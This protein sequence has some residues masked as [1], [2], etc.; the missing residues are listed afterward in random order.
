MATLSLE[1][2]RSLPSPTARY[3][4]FRSRFRQLSLDEVRI[5]LVT[6][7]ALLCLVMFAPVGSR[8][9]LD[10]RAMLSAMLEAGGMPLVYS[11]PAL[12]RAPPNQPA[13]FDHSDIRMLLRDQHYSGDAL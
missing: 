10:E 12:C 9:S 1:A 6:L 4:E 7:T 8:H 2:A 3:R 11:P 5:L 13:R